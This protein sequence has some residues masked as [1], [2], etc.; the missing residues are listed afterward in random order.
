M[1]EEEWRWALLPAC[2]EAVTH[3]V[4]TQSRY[5]SLDYSPV[6][7]LF[8]CPFFFHCGIQDFQAP[9]NTHTQRHAPFQAFISTL[10]CPSLSPLPYLS[11]NVFAPSSLSLYLSL[12]HR[13]YQPAEHD[14]L[15]FFFLQKWSNGWIRKL[16]GHKGM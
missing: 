5:L 12:T 11:A 3:T 10:L 13:L 6:L 14:G 1:M 8:K 9:V 4:S 16:R 15:F 2:L 7:R